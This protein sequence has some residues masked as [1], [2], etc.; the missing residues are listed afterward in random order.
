MPARIYDTKA[1]YKGEFAG[2]HV[3]ENSIVRIEIVHH[4]YVA[5]GRPGSMNIEIDK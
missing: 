2:L 1:I 3:F 4:V 5:L